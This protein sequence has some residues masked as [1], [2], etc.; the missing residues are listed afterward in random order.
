MKANLGVIALIA[1]IAFA[2]P[3]AER[4]TYAL[5]P[6][7]GTDVG[8][9]AGDLRD[10]NGMKMKVLWCPPG[11]FTMGSPKSEEGRGEEDEDQVDVVL[12][13][14]FWLGKTEVSQG[15]WKQ[16]MGTTPWKDESNVEEGREY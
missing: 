3:G 15:Q 13:R 5:E 11:K 7:N 9:K 6:G 16:L 12:S 8:K 1:I 2:I 14:G 10:D 4:T